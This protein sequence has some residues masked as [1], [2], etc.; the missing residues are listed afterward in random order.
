[1]YSQPGQ[2]LVSL[3]TY[4][5]TKQLLYIF[6][7]AFLGIAND[8]S[9]VLVGLVVRSRRKRLGD[10][11]KFKKSSAEAKSKPK[12]ITTRMKSTK[13]FSLMKNRN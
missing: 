12:L 13:T 9:E 6:I 5:K 11:S 10:S 7:L 4:T 3:V 1:M 2:S 8:E